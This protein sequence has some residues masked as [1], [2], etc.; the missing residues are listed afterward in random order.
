MD[1]A[2]FVLLHLHGCSCWGSGRGTGNTHLLCSPTALGC[3]G[4][5]ARVTPECAWLWNAQVT[6]HMG[7]MTEGNPGQLL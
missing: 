4:I 6:W 1:L 3:H 2:G 7:E 5:K